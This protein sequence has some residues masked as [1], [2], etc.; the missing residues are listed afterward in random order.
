MMIALMALVVGLAVT[1]PPGP[2][3]RPLTTVQVFD[4]DPKGMADLAPDGDLWDLKSIRATSSPEGFFLV[5]GYKGERH[6]TLRLP[7]ETDVCRLTGT[8]RTPK[9]SCR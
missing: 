5:C 9:V 6:V 8:A 7:R 3:G 2:D 4:G 1:C